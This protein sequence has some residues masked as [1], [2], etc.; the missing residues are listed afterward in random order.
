MAMIRKG[1]VCKIGGRDMKAQANF[2]AE[3]FQTAA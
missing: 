1:Q 2:I 3:L